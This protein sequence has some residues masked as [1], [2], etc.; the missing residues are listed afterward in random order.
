[1]EFFEIYASRMDNNNN[2]SIKFKVLKTE[3]R[4]DFLFSVMLIQ[5]SKKLNKL[6]F[7]II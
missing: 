3:N 5:Y 2:V 4:S 6:L 1:M 7:S